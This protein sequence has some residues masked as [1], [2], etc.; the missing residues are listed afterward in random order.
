MTPCRGINNVMNLVY[1]CLFQIEQAVLL[2]QGLDEAQYTMAHMHCFG[3]S[4]GGHLRHCVEHFECFLAGYEDGKVD[5]TS[6]A[7]EKDLETSPTLAGKRLEAIAGRLRS[8]EKEGYSHTRK[9]TVKGDLKGVP[10]EEITWQDSSV[11]RELQFLASH[12]IHHF[13]LVAIMCQA[14]G[15]TPAEGFGFAPST[16]VHLEKQQQVGS[17]GA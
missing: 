8:L 15:V 3:G 13:A 1:G 12:T 5:Y 4:I 14:L 6:R 10:E 7:R 9:I 11:G 16:L 17:G 2:L